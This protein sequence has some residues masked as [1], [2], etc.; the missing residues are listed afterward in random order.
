MSEQLTLAPKK[1]LPAED[2]A[3][4]LTHWQVL[5]VVYIH[6]HGRL[7]IGKLQP[8]KPT[9]ELVD[10]G[11]LKR[12]A[13]STVTNSYLVPGHRF[14]SVLENLWRSGRVGRPEEVMA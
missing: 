4:S 6:A 5:D 3:A 9:Q 11:V 12:V 10:A 1:A 14:R 13:G 2:L 8:W 7:Q